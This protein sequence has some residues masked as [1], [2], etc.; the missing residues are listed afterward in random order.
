MF[1]FI[2][3]RSFH[4][5]KDMMA[6]AGL[7]Y[8]KKQHKLYEDKLRWKKMDVVSVKAAVAANKSDVTANA[9]YV[10]VLSEAMKMPLEMTYAD[11][12]RQNYSLTTPGIKQGDYERG[13]NAP[14]L[15]YLFDRTYH[16]NRKL[17]NGL[18]LTYS[19]EQH[20]SYVHALR[21]QEMKA[22][23]V[24]GAIRANKMDKPVKAD[25]A[26]YYVKYDKKEGGFEPV[27]EREIKQCKESSE[28]AALKINREKRPIV[29]KYLTTL[30]DVVGVSLTASFDMNLNH[31]HIGRNMFI[32]GE[33]YAFECHQPWTVRSTVL[34]RSVLAA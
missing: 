33:K 26:S 21:G 34:G 22:M 14:F 16:R 30:S 11:K 24:K 29:D 13:E 28:K 20:Q 19:A 12:G 23:S 4:R 8:S 18:G 27:D 5:N 32:L 3:D 15:A 6:A 25:E 2:Y 7:T 1:K 31:K 10:E 17:L 9:K